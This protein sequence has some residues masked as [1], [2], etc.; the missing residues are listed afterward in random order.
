MNT[1]Y[2]FTLAKTD[3]ITQTLRDKYQAITYNRSDSQYLKEEHF[4]EADKV[5]PHVM[6][7]LQESYPVD[8]QIHSECFN[9]KYVTAHHAIIPTMSDF[10]SKHYCLMNGKCM[11]KYAVITSCNFYHQL[12]NDK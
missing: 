2:G 11:K 10:L 6:A 1:K 5:L 4:T 8:Y 9:D 7:K 12:K 3:Q